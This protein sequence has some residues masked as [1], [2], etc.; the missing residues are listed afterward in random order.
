MTVI[1]SKR[2]TERSYLESKYQDLQFG[3]DQWDLCFCWLRNATNPKYGGSPDWQGDTF[4]ES[5][6]AKRYPL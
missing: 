5:E 2:M 6:L 4:T 1:N 3:S